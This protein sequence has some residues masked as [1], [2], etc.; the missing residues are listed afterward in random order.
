MPGSSCS[1]TYKHTKTNR[2]EE[3][4]SFGCWVRPRLELR[5]PEKEITLCIK[6]TDTPWLHGHGKAYLHHSGPLPCWATCDS[7]R[8]RTGG[9]RWVEGKGVEG[10]EGRGGD[11][12]GI[13]KEIK[14][15][16]TAHAGQVARY[17]EV[18]PAHRVV[19]VRD[20]P[21]WRRPKGRPTTLVAGAS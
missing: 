1:N 16:N 9:R 18:D 19:S 12:V 20:N 21:V 6:P 7:R 15:E 2:V 17:L 4:N 5:P 14:K 10:Q 11:V 13:Y 3:F 8:V